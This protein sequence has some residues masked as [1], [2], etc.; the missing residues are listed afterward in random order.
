MEAVVFV[1]RQ[2]KRIV[3]ARV[4]VGHVNIF[5]FVVDRRLRSADMRL[6]RNVLRR[7]VRHFARPTQIAKATIA[8]KVV[9]LFVS[10]RCLDSR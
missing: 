3:R 4:V 5:L 7:V 10:R 8:M 6:L 9:A 2:G 1:V